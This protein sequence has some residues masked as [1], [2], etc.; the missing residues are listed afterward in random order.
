M[1]HQGQGI[2]TAL[3]RT[4]VRWAREHGYAAVL[5]TGAPDGLFAY[6]RWPGH[7][8]WTAYARLGAGPRAA[9]RD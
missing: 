7:M 5:A 8:P 2:G 4:S 3:C 1:Q 6:A 9:G